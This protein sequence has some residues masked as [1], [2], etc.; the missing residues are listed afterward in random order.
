MGTNA[1]VWRFESGVAS[2]AKSACLSETCCV[3]EL[4]GRRH[5]R[6]A[7]P[8]PSAKVVALSQRVSTL[9]RARVICSAAQIR[10]RR[11]LPL[12]IVPSVCPH[13]CPSAC[14]LQVERIK[15]APA[16]AGGQ[17]RGRSQAGRRRACTSVRGIAKKGGDRRGAV[18]QSCFRGGYRHQSVDERRPGPAER[19]RRLSRYLC[20]AQPGVRAK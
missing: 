10:R 19:R 16:E 9:R 2:G 1:V 5:A 7:T 8:C 15:P 17:R 13:D 12:D 4:R 11:S 3:G 20:M 18:A 6:P 14:A